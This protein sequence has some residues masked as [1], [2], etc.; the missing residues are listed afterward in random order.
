MSG[1]HRLLL[2]QWLKEED[3][4][5][6]RV[7]L[8]EA[9]LDGTR[10]DITSLYYAFFAFHGASVL[11]LFLSASI[12]SEP[13]PSSWQCSLVPPLALNPAV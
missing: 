4:L 7:A 11:V 1:T 13:S 6:R 2:K 10:L 8:Q 3:L 5:A 9:R 12:P